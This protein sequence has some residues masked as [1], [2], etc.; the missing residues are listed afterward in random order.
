MIDTSRLLR[1]AVG[2]VLVHLL[3]SERLTELSK[4]HGVVS[5]VTIRLC[6]LN[7]QSLVNTLVPNPKS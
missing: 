5:A 2:L 1:L 4:K 6:H 3:I 7:S